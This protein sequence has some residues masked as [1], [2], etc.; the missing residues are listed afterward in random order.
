M[1]AY[2]LWSSD[3]DRQIDRQTDRQTGTTTCSAWCNT[4]NIFSISLYLR[5]CNHARYF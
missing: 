2:G 4:R 5:W 1:T 3:T